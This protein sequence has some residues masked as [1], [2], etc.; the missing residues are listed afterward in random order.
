MLAPHDAV[1]VL[2]PPHGADT[3]TLAL[4]STNVACCVARLV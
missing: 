4:H 1:Q 3:H 2:P